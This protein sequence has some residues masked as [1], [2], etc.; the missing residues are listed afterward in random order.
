MKCQI[1]GKKELAH[2]GGLVSAGLR[3]CRNCIIDEPKKAKPIIKQAHAESRKPFASLPD[4]PPRATK[5]VK[6]T[7][8]VNQCQI[9]EGERGFCGLRTCRNGRLI[10]LSGT[11]RYGVV[12]WYHDPLP[13]NC[14]A[15]WVCPE[16]KMYGYSNL[17]VFLGA[18]SF[19]CLFCQNW[20]YRHMA[21]SISPVRT[22]QALADA[23]DK[24]THCICYFGGDP[25]PQMPYALQTARIALKQNKGRTLRICWESNGSMNR[26]FLKQAA[27][28]SMDSGGIIKFDLKAFNENLHKALTGVTNRQTLE[29]FRYLAE[30][31][32]Q[33][34]DPP[35]LVASTLLIP[36]YIEREEVSKI[37]KFIANL[38]PNVPYSL[39]AFYPC[40]FMDDLP[41][42]SRK[43]AEECQ[44][45]AFSAGLKRVKIGNPHLLS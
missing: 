27:Q 12:S 36:G 37:A 3:V 23:T 44:K 41:T 16:S 11:A 7:F 25:T 26:K 35:F 31:G 29:N 21:Q 38:N 5:G 42:T 15:D 32:K 24:K 2:R 28:L 34:E 39:L 43:Q 40:F 20:H 17:A 4:G 13:T 14:V 18:C 6:C 30:L 45:A 8:C 9:G 1:C 22:A 19:N 10:Q 33:R